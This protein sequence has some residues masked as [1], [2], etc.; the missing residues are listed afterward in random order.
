MKLTGILSTSVMNLGDRSSQ[1]G[2]VVAPGERLGRKRT[3]IQLCAVEGLC[4]TK[5]HKRAHT[6]CCSTP[7]HAW[8][9]VTTARLGGRGG[10]CVFGL[11]FCLH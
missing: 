10:G 6:Q 11:V 8:Q 7:V 3:S 2:I 1:H 4:G 9:T 5:Q